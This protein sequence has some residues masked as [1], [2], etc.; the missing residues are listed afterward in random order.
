MREERTLILSK[1]VGCEVKVGVHQLVKKKKCMLKEYYLAKRK[2]KICHNF[3]WD[4]MNI[5]VGNVQ[6]NKPNIQHRLLSSLHMWKPQTDHP[7]YWMVTIRC[8]EVSLGDIDE[9]MLAILHRNP[10]RQKGNIDQDLEESTA[11]VPAIKEWK[12][13]EA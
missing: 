3:N 2:V 4:N 11:K 8:W 1:N 5:T 10:A 6:R 12:E 9:G 7:D 13:S